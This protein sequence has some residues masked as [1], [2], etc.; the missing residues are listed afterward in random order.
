MKKE[1]IL[2]VIGILLFGI[3]GNMV[4][5]ENKSSAKQGN[6]VISPMG[7]GGNQTSSGMNNKSQEQKQIKT[8]EENQGLGK[9]IRNNVRAGIYTSESGEKIRVS[10][11]ARNK[12]RLQVGN[13]SAD[14]ECNITQ[15]QV[16]NRTRLKVKLSNGR[17]AELKIMPNVAA[18]RALERLRL[19]VC[20]EENNCSLQL[21]EVGKGNETKLAYEVQVERHMRILGLFKTKAKVKAEVDAEN[22]EV[23]NVKKPWWAFLAYEPRE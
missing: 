18:E 17:N 7:S 21:K 4:L 3:V 8:Q 1:A 2:L 5:A 13:V 14:C 10:E 23:I 11:M 20:S 12:I 19:K 16:Q 22:G 9:T 6:A 15:E